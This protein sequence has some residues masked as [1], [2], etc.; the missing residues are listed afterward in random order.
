MKRFTDCKTVEEARKYNPWATHCMSA[1][2]GFRLF[3]SEQEF[4]KYALENMLPKM[5]NLFEE[6]E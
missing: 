5:K 2:G 4:E 6:D 1:S 3:D